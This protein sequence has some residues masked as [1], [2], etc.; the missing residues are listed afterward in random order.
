VIVVDTNVIAYLFIPGDHSSEARRAYLRDPAWC[1][2]I[3]WRSEFRNVLALYL[4]KKQLSLDAA[5]TIARGAEGL[6][7]PRE[8]Q[9]AA[10]AVLPLLETSI[11][12]AYDCEFVALARQLEVSLVTSDKQ[13]LRAF[14]KIAVS[15]GEF[16]KSK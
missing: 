15:L 3:L 12:S 8:Y 11:C 5:I 13:I 4:R 7:E 6:L 2:P 10:N 14:P 9:L 16:G 1:A